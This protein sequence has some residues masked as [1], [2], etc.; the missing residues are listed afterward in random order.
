ML[1]AITGGQEIF[2]EYRGRRAFGHM[3]VDEFVITGG[4]QPGFASSN[5]QTPEPH[6]GLC[7]ACALRLIRHFNPASPKIRSNS[8]FL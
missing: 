3:P 6:K 7:N 5:C 4:K 8:L 2:R 1:F